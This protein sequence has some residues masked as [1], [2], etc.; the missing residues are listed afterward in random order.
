M[1]VLVVLAVGG[2]FM[3]QHNQTSNTQSNGT[4]SIDYGKAS[5]DQTTAGDQ[6]KSNSVKG[7][8]TDTPPS[9]STQP[10]SNK[11]VAEVSITAK[12]QTSQAYQI[13]FQI[14]AL[15]EN[16]TCTLTLTKGSTVVT[17]TAS[18]QNLSNTSTCTGFDIPVSELSSGSWQLGLNVDSPTITGVINST[19]TVQ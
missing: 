16:G 5:T 13:R 6:I 9:P 12:N 14:D 15:I 4:N 18:V 8:N 3:Y 2:Y 10:G 17:K 11:K 19:I 1:A 7:N